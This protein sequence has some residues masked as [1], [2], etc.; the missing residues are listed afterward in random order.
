MYFGSLFIITYG[1]LKYVLISE[2]YR[3]AEAPFQVFVRFVVQI[4]VEIMYADEYMV[5]ILS[6]CHYFLTL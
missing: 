5:I 1:S 4:F 6:L 3:E 2:G